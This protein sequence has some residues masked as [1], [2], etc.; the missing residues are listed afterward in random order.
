MLGM[1]RSGTSVVAASLDRCGFGVHGEHVAAAQDNPAGY[2]EPRAVVEAHDRF[3]TEIGRSWSDPR[4]MPD[5][6]FEGPAAQRARDTLKRYFENHLAEAEAWAIKDPRVCR[7]LPLW[8]PIL[9][10]MP[11][12]FLHV[13]RAPSSVAES[14][15]VRDRINLRRAQLLWLRSHLESEQETRGAR[16]AWLA[17]ETLR[18]DEATQSTASFLGVDGSW[19]EAVD[20]LFEPSLV[21]H[22]D[23]QDAA[24]HPWLR[25]ASEALR[26]LCESGNESALPALD[27]LWQRLRTA[28]DLLEAEELAGGDGHHI[29]RYLQLRNAV[30]LQTRTVEAQRSEVEALRRELPDLQQLAERLEARADEPLPQRWLRRNLEEARET[31]HDSNTRLATAEERLLDRFTSGTESEVRGVENLDAG[32][33]SSLVRLFEALDQALARMDQRR[34][35]EFEAAESSR[36]GT[37]EELSEL[38]EGLAKTL[39]WLQEIRSSHRDSIDGPL[40]RLESR[41]GELL[42]RSLEYSARLEGD[43]RASQGAHEEL[44]RRNGRLEQ[45]KVR[46]EEQGTMLR[47]ELALLQSHEGRELDRLRKELDR[48]GRAN[49]LRETE[50]TDLRIRLESARADGRSLEKEA[51]GLRVALHDVEVRERLAVQEVVQLESRRSWRYTHLFRRWLGA[52]RQWTG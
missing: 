24:D 3:L 43:L 29:E 7:L 47:R 27:D 21:H 13:I 40:R 25:K 41:H 33:G 32:T 46:L 30:E 22:R 17:F 42:D 36:R 15:R 48:L 23:Q 12:R 52:W 51:L 8:T 44:V 31:V 37:Q 26:S 28:D 20:I 45:Q 38:R 6:A 19:A 34:R 1:H 16:R 18:E 39:R 2:F 10:G 11:V 50:L 9:D 14:L 49:G 5:A 4:P 35:A